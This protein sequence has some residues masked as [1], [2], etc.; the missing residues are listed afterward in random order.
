M[1]IAVVLGN[2]G[3]KHIYSRNGAEFINDAT[4]RIPG[5]NPNSDLKVDDGYI[6]IIWR[7]IGDG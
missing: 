2:V 3:D 1:G 7:F 5:L 4:F 6:M